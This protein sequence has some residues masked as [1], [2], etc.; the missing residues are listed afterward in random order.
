[1]MNYIHVLRLQEA[2]LLFAQEKMLVK[3]LIF[4]M[5]KIKKFMALTQQVNTPHR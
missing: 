5:K 3:F 4:Q 1:M 2:D